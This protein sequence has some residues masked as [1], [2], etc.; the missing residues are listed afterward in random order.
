MQREHQQRDSQH[1]PQ[2]FSHSA[3][4]PSPYNYFPALFVTRTLF[5]VHVCHTQPDLFP[6]VAVMAT[7]AALPVATV[8]NIV[9][10]MATAAGIGHGNFLV[11]RTLV[12]G[13]AVVGG[14]LVEAVQLE[15]GLVVIEVPG[16]PVARVVTCLAF[17]AQLA[18]VDILFLVTRPAVRLRILESRGRMT[19]PARHQQMASEQGKG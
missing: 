1:T 2:H 16:F 5:F 6:V 9:A 12:A 14:L 13:I 15:I 7:L 19:F 8:V 4:D 10:I 3:H 11:H 18:L 17:G